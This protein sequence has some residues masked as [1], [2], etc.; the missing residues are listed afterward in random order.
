MTDARIKF[1]SD[2]E[3]GVRVQRKN[4]RTNETK[5]GKMVEVERVVSEA[6]RNR[7]GDGGKRWATP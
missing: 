4:E 1:L 2:Y 5:R 7:V 6:E 3:R